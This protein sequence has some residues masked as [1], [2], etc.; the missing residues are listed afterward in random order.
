MPLITKSRP[1]RAL[2]DHEKSGPIVRV[3]LLCWDIAHPQLGKRLELAH[4][5]DSFAQLA[6]NLDWQTMP[7]LRHPLNS[8]QAV[9]VTDRSSRVVWVSRGFSRMTGYQ[10]NE[11]L[12]K[13][14]A[15]LQGPLT[16]LT[17]RA[18]VRQR[19]ARCEA[20][21]TTIQNYRKD[22][23]PY[24]CRISIDPLYNKQ[25]ECTHF[26]AIEEEFVK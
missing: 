4:D 3:P 17:T 14:P 26:M 20:V 23:T 19:L 1:V 22:Q 25:A 13:T 5:L 6:T 12:G 15:L 2:S 8:G 9:V 24:W 16:S 10:P 7:E 18:F 21:T 11:M